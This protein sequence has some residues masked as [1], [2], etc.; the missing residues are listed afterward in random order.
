MTNVAGEKLMAE[1]IGVRI[2]FMGDLRAVIESSDLKL[3][4]PRGTRVGDLLKS[5]AEQYGDPFAKWLFTGSGELHHS[6][7][8]FVNGENIQDIGGLSVVLGEQGDQVEIIMLP[9]FE[10]G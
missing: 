6:I 9:M 3:T 8:I 7:V 1:D 2:R 5:L 10:G 4:L